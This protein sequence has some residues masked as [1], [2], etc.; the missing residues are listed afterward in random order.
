[1]DNT[2]ISNHIEDIVI[3][4]RTNAKT[5]KQRCQSVN[6]IGYTQEILN[7]LRPASPFVAGGYPTALL[8][9]PRLNQI[10][11]TNNGDLFAANIASVNIENFQNRIPHHY[12]SD[13]DLYFSSA[14]DY[15]LAFEI[16]T[17][18]LFP[19]EIKEIFSTENADTIEFFY[20]DPCRI[21]L[22][23][24]SAGRRVFANSKAKLN[25]KIQLIKKVKQPPSSLLKT[26]DFINCAI[27]YCLS[28]DIFFY[29][30]DF[31][32][33]FQRGEL[34]ILNPWMLND[35]SH[36][37]TDNIIVQIYRFKKYCKRWGLTLGDK[38][39]E[40]LIDVY[41][42]NPN[43]RTTKDHVCR[44]ESGQYKDL[45]IEINLAKGTNIWKAI[46][47]LFS[48]NKHWS[49]YEDPHKILKDPSVNKF[50]HIKCLKG[51]EISSPTH[52][53]SKP[54]LF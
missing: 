54:C 39:F 9:A 4:T 23:K 7:A 52:S 27:G 32:D 24:N 15:N 42:K 16:I 12:Y 13:Y 2:I 46:R 14:S 8:L 40:K 22:Q 1:M 51:I 30:K 49:S 53:I 11:Q 21:M 31:F 35:I 45:D 3:S 41:E 36:E 5:P 50:E 43:I 6:A 10:K 33:T 48:T 29:H 37:S 28:T 38:A 19:A 17:S 26:F 47:K 34:E 20:Q 44:P 18:P 25:I